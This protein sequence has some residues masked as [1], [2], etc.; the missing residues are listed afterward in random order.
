MKIALVTTTINVPAVL[1]WYR[2]CDADR[3][4]KFFVV[5]DL[6]TPHRSTEELCAKLGAEYLHPDTPGRWKCDPAIGFNTIQRRNLGFLA[7]LEWGADAVVSID[8]DNMGL[9]TTYFDAHKKALFG[10][11]AGVQVT[12]EHD[13]VDPGAYLRPQAKHRGFPTQVSHSPFYSAV[14]GKKIGVSA[15]MCLGDPDVDAATRIV[16]APDVQQVSLLAEAGFIVN[17]KTWT[18]FNSQNTAMLRQFIPAWGMIPFTGRYDD[19]YASLIA[20]RVMR[21]YDYYVRFGKPYV[22]QERNSHNLIRDLRGE[23]DGMDNVVKLAGVLDH[24]QLSGRSVIDDC[25]RIWA[26]LKNCDWMPGRSIAA[27]EAWLD[28]CESVL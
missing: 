23:I 9:A 21:E 25:R 7:A 27:M 18:V 26:S 24:T 17:N 11:F 6:K 28:D 13:W 14:T 5:G 10:R 1:E 19:I 15:G 16:S 20:Q 12:G 4:V 8:D 2:V 22:F 3:F